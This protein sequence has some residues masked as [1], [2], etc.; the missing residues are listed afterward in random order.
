ME[1]GS[2]TANCN[3]RMSFEEL[4]SD[5]GKIFSNNDDEGTDGNSNHDK[6]KSHDSS[7]L[8]LSSMT[9][10]SKAASYGSCNCDECFLPA[11]S[12]MIPSTI[13][14]AV[15][16]YKRQRP[17]KR[18]QDRVLVKRQDEISIWEWVLP[19]RAEPLLEFGSSHRL[20]YVKRLPGTL[21][22]IGQDGIVGSKQEEES[23]LLLDWKQ[24]DVIFAKSNGGRAVGYVHA[25]KTVNDDE[26]EESVHATLLICKVPDK[27][28]TPRR[29]NEN[30]LLIPSWDD[31]IRN[32]AVDMLREIPEETTTRILSDTQTK[33]VIECMENYS[34]SA[35]H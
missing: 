8:F 29:E 6:H 13:A 26:N 2:I 28:E 16:N 35:S 17:L 21:Q 10:A 5:D 4:Q 25:R 22:T 1:F 3:I 20:V 24:G 19:L 18:T 9:F 31:R 30:R 7:S 27:K 33:I 12:S 15:L 34:Y 14:N 32:L 11:G 23:R